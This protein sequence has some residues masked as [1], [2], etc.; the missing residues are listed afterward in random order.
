MNEPAPALMKNGVFVNEHIFPI[1]SYIP[2]TLSEFLMQGI[3][4]NLLGIS[5]Y[6]IRYTFLEPKSGVPALLVAK[7]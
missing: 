6:Q 1:K 7:T 5:T 2:T 3:S 4:F